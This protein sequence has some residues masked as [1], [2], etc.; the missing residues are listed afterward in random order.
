MKLRILM[1]GA[2]SVMALFLFTFPGSGIFQ[3]F[4]GCDQA[5][6][7]EGSSAVFPKADKDGEYAGRYPYPIW[8]VVDPDPSGLNGR[9]AA[10]FP[11]DWDSCNARWPK[12]DESMYQWPVIRTFRKG[13]L[14]MGQ[15]TNAG[16]AVMGAFIRVGN[17]EKVER[18]LFVKLGLNGELCFVRAKSQY[19]EPVKLYTPKPDKNGDY[20]PEALWLK[21]QVVDKD[22]GGLNCRCS[23][24]FPSNPVTAPS[25]S[26]P[27]LNIQQWPVVETLKSGTELST[28]F[29]N[30][31]LSIV[32][33]T[34]GKPWLL[35]SIYDREKKQTF[36]CF[37]RANSRFIKP[38]AD[39][40]IPD[41][42]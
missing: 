4:C 24:D 28:F 15:T 1:I 33:D 31:G 14:L 21:W 34:G 19:I 20:S 16:S 41:H 22:P 8:R 5:C 36:P 38:I 11:K 17:A 25:S 23:T 13:S 30:E 26:W 32:K 7:G 2:L 10:D 29:T 6:A 35:I 3:P 18:W 9:L 12:M 27:K 40:H 39:Y 37:V 42:Y